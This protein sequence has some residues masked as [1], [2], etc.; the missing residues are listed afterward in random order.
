[1]I[2][3]GRSGSFGKGKVGINQNEKDMKKVVLIIT[4]KFKEK[5]LKNLKNRP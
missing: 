1:M 5:K 2:E 3:W 4:L